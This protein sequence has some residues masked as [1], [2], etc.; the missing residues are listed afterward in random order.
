LTGDRD[1]IE[2]CLQ[3]I[4]ALGYFGPQRFGRERSNLRRV[5]EWSMGGE[6]PRDRAQR[7]FAL[8]ARSQLFNEVLAARVAH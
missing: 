8:S 7:S 2:A 4:A 1:R 5:R 6:E 3:R